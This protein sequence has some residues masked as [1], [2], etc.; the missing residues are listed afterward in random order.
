MNRDVPLCC[1]CDEPLLQGEQLGSGMVNNKPVHH[2]CFFRAIS[3][4][5]NHIR[6]SCTCCGGTEPPDPPGLTRREAAR[7]AVLA[8]VERESKTYDTALLDAARKTC[9]E[10]GFDWRDPRTGITHPAPL[11]AARR[12]PL[13]IW[14]VYCRPS[15]YPT[16]YI[17]RKFLLDKSTDEIV[18]SPTIEGIHREMM[19]RRLIW[20]D[21]QAGDDPTIV[22]TWV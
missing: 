19:R 21:R 22:E 3:G 11:C 6:G 16:E 7:E 14:T 13:A 15:D 4:G 10:Q 20:M 5:A 12:P 1:L 17:A 9:H 2:E 8:F 18:R